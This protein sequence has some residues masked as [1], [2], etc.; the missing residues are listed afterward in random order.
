MSSTATTSVR[1][2]LKGPDDWIPLLEMVKS[3]ATT[4]QVWEYVDPSRSA[5]VIPKLVEPQWPEPSDLPLSD[6]ERAGTMTAA[7]KEELSELR[8]LYKIRLNRY[9]QRK[10]SIASLRRF[11]QETVHP[12]RIHYTFNCDSVHQMLVNLQQRLK[13]K[14]DVRRYQLIDQYRGLQ[15]SPRHSFKTSFHLTCCST[16]VPQSNPIYP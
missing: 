11:I 4:G 8:S 3:T 9:D 5:D 2:I 15:E 16:Q 6:A 10:A 14:D 12:D 7:H 13:P 1:A